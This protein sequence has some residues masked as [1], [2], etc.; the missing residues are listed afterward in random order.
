MESNPSG[1]RPFYS[2]FAD[3]YDHVVT[4]PVGPWTEAVEGA[5]ASRGVD[6]GTLVDA[7][8]GT[9]RHAAAFAALGHRITLLDASAEL[10]AVASARCPEAP[11]HLDDLRD[12]RLRG[13]FDVL[14][15]RGVLN[16]LLED[17]DRDAAV[18]S[19]AR[20]LRPGGVLALDVR[21]AGRSREKA[22][23]APRSTTVPRDAGGAVTFTS[24]SQWDDGLLVVA[25]EH[26]EHRPDGAVDLR[27]HTFRMRPWTEQEVRERLGRAGFVDV[28]TGP[29][30]GGR[31]DRLF[32]TAVRRT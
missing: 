7:G 5:L 4:D 15:C 11:A 18:L 17:D 22:D 25:E 19:S 27:E 12:P 10:L 13:P 28:V 24:R 26:R 20:L 1:A 6:R 29:G 32:V 3:L 9:G 21:D 30:V 14:T 16:D 2:A 31:W 8:C 23:G